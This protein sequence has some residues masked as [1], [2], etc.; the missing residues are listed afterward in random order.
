MKKGV[1]KSVLD[2]EL[3][4][5]LQMKKQYEN[6]LEKLPRGCLIAKKIR[7]NTYYYIV[8]REG[9][10]VRYHYKGKLSQEEID[11]LKSAQEL[12]T[13]YRKHLSAVNKQI[14]YLRSCLRGKEPI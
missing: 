1:I 13:K 8:K 6:E 10:K 11:R 5:S 2:E 7:G 14:K 3:Q 12:R 9:K 4:N